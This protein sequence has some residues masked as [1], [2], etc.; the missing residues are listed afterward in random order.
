VTVALADAVSLRLAVLV[1]VMVAVSD[2]VLVHVAEA[3]AVDVSDPLPL[4]LN[5]PVGDTDALRDGD[6]DAVPLIVEVAVSEAV[7]EPEAV[8]V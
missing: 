6:F 4:L 7:E 1:L 3:E 8:A 2:A 5:V